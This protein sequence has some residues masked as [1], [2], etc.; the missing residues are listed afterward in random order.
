[1]N[2]THRIRW[3]AGLLLTC[4]FGIAHAF[5]ISVA[6]TAVMI[7]PKTGFAHLELSN[8]SNQ[9]RLFTVEAGDPALTHCY[10]VS[11]RQITLP[12]NG[13][14]TVRLQYNCPLQD[15]TEHSLLYF[16]EMP[17]VD[18]STASSSQLEFRLRLGLKVKTQQSVL[19]SLF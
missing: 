19:G 6:P 17:T 18:N 14:Q 12:P 1:M 9:T 5:G 15:I 4:S 3:T 8:Q 7:N 13:S 2:T 16:T 10:K 11:P